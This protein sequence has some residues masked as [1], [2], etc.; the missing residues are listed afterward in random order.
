MGRE[1]E[2]TPRELMRKQSFDI[3]IDSLFVPRSLCAAVFFAL[4]SMLLAPVLL[5][6]GAA[7]DENPCGI[8]T[9]PEVPA[10]R[11]IPIPT[12]HAFR[13]RLKELGYIEGKISPSNFA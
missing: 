4:C 6:S 9:K 13:Q 11:R 7:D 8:G 5:G 1:P 3:S 2:K 12:T 10:V